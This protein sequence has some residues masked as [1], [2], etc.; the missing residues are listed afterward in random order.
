LVLGVLAA[1]SGEEGR[2]RE[3]QHDRAHRREGRDERLEQRGVPGRD[4][5][6]DR[7]PARSELC[8]EIEER[9]QVTLCW[10]RHGKHVWLVAA[11]AGMLL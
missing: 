5:D 7:D 1:P 8:Y 3:R 4:G 10:E 6:G 11:I 9:G 2:G